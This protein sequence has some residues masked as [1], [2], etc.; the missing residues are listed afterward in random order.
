MRYEISASIMIMRSEMGVNLADKAQPSS[1]V[2]AL[3]L[4]NNEDD[5]WPSDTP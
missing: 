5:V 4:L 3:Q 2:P 1:Y